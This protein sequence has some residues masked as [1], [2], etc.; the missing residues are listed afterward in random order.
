MASTIDDAPQDETEVPSVARRKMS[1]QAKIKISLVVAIAIIVIVSFLAY[2]LSLNQG[3]PVDGL[4]MVTNRSTT[5]TDTVFTITAMSSD[6][7]IL[8][9]DVYV[10][11]KNASGIVINTEP[12]SVANGTHGFNYLPADTSNHLS[13]GDVFLLSKNYQQGCTVTL[14][15]QGAT[16]Q[17]CVM[18]V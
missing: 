7:P 1:R 17:Y 16:G 10:M 5:A 8:K 2:V 9:S 6:P 4:T 14:V 15:N 18:T 12:L 13:V 11:V 3:G